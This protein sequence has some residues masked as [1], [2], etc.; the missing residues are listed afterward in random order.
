MLAKQYQITLDALMRANP[1]LDPY[2]LRIGMQLCIP[3]SEENPHEMQAGAIAPVQ[4]FQNKVYSTQ[5]GVY[6]DKNSGSV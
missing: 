6:A 4:G 2:N 3:I 1:D 5:R